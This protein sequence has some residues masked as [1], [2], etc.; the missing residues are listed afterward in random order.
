MQ[1]SRH[2][3]LDGWTS[4]RDFTV[5]TV[6]LR[7]WALSTFFSTKRDIYDFLI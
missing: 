1:R 4:V 2:L 7:E 3:E 6:D 5:F